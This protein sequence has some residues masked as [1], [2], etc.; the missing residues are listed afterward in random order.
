MFYHF[1]L[2]TGHVILIFDLF[3]KKTPPEILTSFEDDQQNFSV[4]GTGQEHRT[5]RK[6]R[7]N[8]LPTISTEVVGVK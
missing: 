4:I 3:Q 1:N 2:P 7:T 5:T 6:I 8:Y